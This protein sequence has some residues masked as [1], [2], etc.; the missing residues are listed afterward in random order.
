LAR[1]RRGTRTAESSSLIDV[2]EKACGKR[3]HLVSV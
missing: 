1:P 2:R 3:S